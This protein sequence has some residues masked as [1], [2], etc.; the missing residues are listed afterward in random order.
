MY[1]LLI[2]LPLINALILGFFGF[3]LGNKGSNII[4]MFCMILACI[5][6]FTLVYLNDA[7]DSFSCN[8]RLF[9]WISIGT[10]DIYWSFLFDT[11]TLVMFFV[12][13]TISTLVH[14]YSIEYMEH[15]PHKP[16]FMAYLSLFTFFMLIL[17][18]SENFLQMFIGWE[19]VG[20]CS[21]LL[22]NFWFTRLQANKAAIKAMVM[23]RVSDVGLVMG[24][25][26]LYNTLL[27]FDYP[28]V[29][30][31]V[32]NIIGIDLCFF[33]A[34][35]N[36]LDFIGFCLFIGA[37]GKSAQFMLHTW[38]PDAMEGP[39][40]VSALIHAAT[41]VTA[42]VFLLVRTS[43]IFEHTVFVLAFVSTVG[44]L[45][46]FWG[47]TVGLFQN[48][49]K[50]VIAYSTCSQLGYMIFACGLSNYNVA[51]FH[52]TTHAFFKALLFLGAGSVIHS[53]YDEQDMRR[54]GGLKNLLPLAYSVL[55]IG[56]LSLMGFPF[57]SGFYS[58]DLILESSFMKYILTGHW[59]YWLGCLAALFTTI[60]SVR[61]VY[62]TFLIKPQ[63]FR[64][65]FYGSHESGANI[66]LVLVILLFPTIFLG[67]F[68]RE[69][70]VGFGTAFW[71][72]TIFILP[73][74][75]LGFDIE[76]IPT[77]FKFLPTL[78]VF[79]G[80]VCCL[81]IFYKKNKLLVILNKI[82]SFRLVYTFFNRKWFFDRLYNTLIGQFLFFS[83]SS[84]FYTLLDKG[85]IEQ[86]GP[87]GIQTLFQQL[88]F[89]INKN[90]SGLIFEYIGFFILGVSVLFLLVLFLWS[91][92]ITSIC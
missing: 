3:K 68:L 17:V 58:K 90:Q 71:G 53:V 20:L 87:K 31:L 22:I 66:F 83:G 92:F 29:F 41:M 52:L 54:M 40:P 67:F 62:L 77:F 59:C 30:A 81:F 37:M 6:G 32:T 70:F 23:N 21:Y 34:T 64:V 2:L 61:L 5:C 39:T 45:T 26:T 16:R 18:T 74:N 27:T 19:G 76:F 35:L 7:G 24:V 44:A 28:I 49:L 46:A 63:G 72:N 47:S 10:L 84:V 80:S 15:D 11:L 88:T 14:F 9:P 56:S 50:K 43:H 73:Q 65:T 69:S 55:V 42:G 89:N 85:L 79:F 4:A 1:L 38:L 86:I 91:A 13:I 36:L 75:N 8:I 60:Y 33:G 25:L 12:V 51:I 48:D 82:K 78:L 57:L